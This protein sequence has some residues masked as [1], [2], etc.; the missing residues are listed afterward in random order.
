[1]RGVFDAAASIYLERFLN[2][3]STPVPVPIDTVKDS[4]ARLNELEG[5]LDRQQR[6]NEAGVL[7]VDCLHGGME[8][9]RLLAVLGRA[10][11]REDRNFHTIQV[12]EAALRHHEFARGTPAA[13]VVLVAAA[14]YL[15]AHAPTARAQGQTYEIAQRLHHGERLHEER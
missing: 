14:R 5:L 12:V 13:P 9:D 3:P 2:V 6:V 15:A 10:L 7:V 8:P 4:E 1:M 11:L